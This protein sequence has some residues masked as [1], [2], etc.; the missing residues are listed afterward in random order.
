MTRPKITYDDSQ[1]GATFQ[2]GEI[3][4]C[5]DLGELEEFLDYLEATKHD[6]NL[7]RCRSDAGRLGCVRADLACSR[8]ARN[9]ACPVG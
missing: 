2:T 9:R 7:R 1:W 5:E 8:G 6:T 3:V 4:R